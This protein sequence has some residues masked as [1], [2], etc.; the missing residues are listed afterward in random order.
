M[1]KLASLPFKYY[2]EKAR[3]KKLVRVILLVA[4]V[5]KWTEN[6]CPSKG[7][8]TII[9]VE[10]MTVPTFFIHV[11]GVVMQPFFHGFPI[12]I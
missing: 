2:I 1:G 6:M 10:S 11:I 7:R 5:R 4:L 9:I 3:S 12:C 8:G